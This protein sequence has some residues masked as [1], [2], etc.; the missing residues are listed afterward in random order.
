[1]HTYLA[2]AF[3]LRDPDSVANRDLAD[4]IAA[5]HYE[6]VRI[7]VGEMRHIRA[8]RDVLIAMVASPPFD[9]PLRIATRVPGVSP[10]D[11]PRVLTP[12]GLTPAALETFI[13]IEGPNVSVDGLYNRILATLELVGNE[14]SEQSIR[15]V[16]TEGEDHQ[17]I[18]MAIREWLAPHSTAEYLRSTTLASPPGGNA[19]HATLQTQYRSVL[20]SLHAGY[21]R[22]TVE[23]GADVN[24]ARNAMMG[25]LLAACEAVA[26]AG[27]LVTF[28]P[29]ADP[30]FVSIDPPP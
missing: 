14:R 15:R 13:E 11:P 4:D 26:Q 7:A 22:T 29:V 17:K 27:F 1:M 2:A 28:D 6:I 5:A 19:A 25:S 8:V 9:P 3:S 10:N 16:M 21:S 30:R 18:F 20:E 23:G 12:S 24:T